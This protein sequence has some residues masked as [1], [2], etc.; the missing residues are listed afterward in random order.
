MTND[1][2]F[3]EY[4][5]DDIL[6]RPSKE[7]LVEQIFG[8]HDFTMIFGSSGTGKTFVGIDLALSAITQQPFAGRFKVTRPLTVA[9]MTTEGIGGL[10]NRFRAAAAI[11]QPTPEDW[12]RLHV[13]TDLLQFVDGGTHPLENFITQWKASYDMPLD[14]LILDHLSATIPGKGD[15]D[16]GAATLVQQGLVRLRKELG[17]GVVMIHHTGWKDEHH[18]GMTTYK[19]ISDMQIQ[20]RSLRNPHYMFCRK[21]KDGEPWERLRFDLI[22]DEGS[23]H[24][25]WSAAPETPSQPTEHQYVD[26]IRKAD[27]PLTAR[28]IAAITGH[29]IERVNKALP[30]LAK[31]AKIIKKLQKAG[32]C[33]KTNPYVYS[34]PAE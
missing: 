31:D 11:H 21:N 9:Y 28:E 14:M 15:S 20:V 16:A 24:V 17:A 22:D 30:K 7:W 27:H 33:S 2:R 8:V 19:D 3:E 10:P 6:R 13:F 23:C 4:P 12:K 1:Q 5:G 25:E 32:S 18:R 26:I 29:P 34:I